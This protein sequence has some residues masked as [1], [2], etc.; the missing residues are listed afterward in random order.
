MKRLICIILVLSLGTGAFGS[1]LACRDL[2]LE[3]IFSHEISPNVAPEVLNSQLQS[4]DQIKYKRRGLYTF[5]KEKVTRRKSE[6][7]T[8][9]L[10]RFNDNVEFYKKLLSDQ[11]YRDLQ[12]WNADPRT[13]PR[14]LEETLALMEAANE[15]NPDTAGL[16]VVRRWL[17]SARARD[18]EQMTDLLK[19]KD[20]TRPVETDTQIAKIYL[21]A[22]VPFEQISKVLNTEISPRAVNVIVGR[23]RVAFLTESFE[24]AFEILGTRQTGGLRE[25]LRTFKKDHPNISPLPGAAAQLMTIGAIV[26]GG[27]QGLFLLK[28]MIEKMSKEDLRKLLHGDLSDID[29]RLAKAVRIEDR[30]KLGMVILGLACFAFSIVLVQHTIRYNFFSNTNTTEQRAKLEQ[31]AYDSTKASLDFMHIT[32]TPAE[33]AVEKERIHKLP[34]FDVDARIAPLSKVD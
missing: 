14:D 21:I 3:S 29:P 17:V 4:Y 1:Q 16:N 15:H 9:D 28:G 10:K 34:D 8:F 32:L 20:F 19:F 13:T 33:I 25:S 26:R 31:E 11:N 22:N 5:L 12:I 30:V 18:V 24:K 23:I 27:P 2:F 6:P 7:V